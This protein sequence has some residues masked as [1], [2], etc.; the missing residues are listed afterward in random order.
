[1]RV[2]GTRGTRP[3]G[4]EAATGAIGGRSEIHAHG[5]TGQAP[6]R[7][8]IL[9]GMTQV[10]MRPRFSD[11]LSAEE[12][13]FYDALRDA[14]T[15]SGGSIR[16]TFFSDG[17][18]L[19][20]REEDRH[21]W[22]PALHLHVVTDERVGSKTLHGRFS[23]SSPIWMGFLFIYFLLGCSAVAGACYGLAQWTVGETPWTLLAVPIALFLAAFTYGAAFIGQG[24]GSGDMYTLRSFVDHVRERLDEQRATKQAG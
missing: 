16:G 13:E 14:V 21:L 22:S 8:R 3:A 1:L 10:R 11:P 5:R 20:Q 18:L 7:P 15:T 17:A 24:L 12:T 9:Q 4:L 23:P 6:E 2:G 19:R